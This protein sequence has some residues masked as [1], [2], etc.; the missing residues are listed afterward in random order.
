[1]NGKQND[2][3]DVTSGGDMS[4]EIR[5]VTA[6]VATTGTTV[7]KNSPVPFVKL[8]TIMES[9]LI[10]S[11]PLRL[12]KCNTSNDDEEN[13]DSTSANDDNS[14]DEVKCIFLCEFHATAGPKIA[15]QVPDNYISKELF[16]TV[17][18]YIIPKL[19]LERSFLSV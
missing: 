4:T 1:M 15:A 16:D 5:I 9:G 2:C 3:T 18:R 7:V 6:T 8:P 17:N 10:T 19:Q 12:V 13:E 11:A 14:E